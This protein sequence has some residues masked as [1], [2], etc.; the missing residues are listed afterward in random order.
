MYALVELK[1][2]VVNSVSKRLKELGVEADELELL[3][4]MAPPPSPDLGD[5][6]I[7]LFKYSKQLRLKPVELVKKVIEGLEVEGVEEFKAV[8]G[9]LNFFVD[10]NS[11]VK[12]IL[13]EALREDYGSWNFK[14]RR[15]VE[16]TSAN[17]VHPLHIGHVRNMFLGDSLAKIL[18]NYGND[19]QTRFY[20]NDMGR[21]VAVLVYGLLNLGELEPPADEKPDHWYGKVYSVSN[22][23]IEVKGPEG[24]EWKDVLEDLRSRYPDLVNALEEKLKDKSYD[25]INREI[26]EL[27]KKYEE[28]D[29]ETVRTFRKVVNEVLKGFRESMDNVSVKVEVWDWESDLVWSGL[30]RKILELAKEKGVLKEKEGA[31]VIEFDFLTDEIRERLKIPKGLEI[32]PLVLVRSDGT[33]LYPTRD[34]AYSIKKFEDFNADQVINVIATE[35][36]LPQAQVRLALWALGYKKYAENLIHYAY[37]MVNIPGMKMS[38]RR[39]RMI[40]LDWLIE[41]ALRRVRPLVE[42]RSVLEGEERE[43]IAKIV[44][45]GA[46]KYAMVS[47]SKDKPITFKW[48]EVL[49]FERSSAPYLQYTYARAVGIL[50]KSEEPNLERADFTKAQAHKSLLLRIAEFPEVTKKAGEELAPEK[51]AI[52]LSQL[53]DEFNKFYHEHPVSK[54]PDEGYKHLK[55]AIVKATANVLKRG[56]SLLGIEAPERM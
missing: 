22:A 29:E 38:G 30:V 17:P 5:W 55:L 11:I 28:N 50:R 10:I 36:R 45:V 2:N 27:M 46:I 43:R 31:L 52:Y 48:N 14:G 33:T 35:Q 21:Q 54:E 34:I 56:L 26:S 51:I 4:N 41:E 20:I 24:E 49:N 3:R 32:P 53:A 19:V 13:E 44:A 1:Q 7:P 16:H 12:R 6:G 39:G 40:T 8:G 25:E 37:E 47:V 18:K 23:V 15:V 42:E 9:Y